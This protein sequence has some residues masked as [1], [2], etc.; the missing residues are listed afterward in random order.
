MALV[1][2]PQGLVRRGN[3]WHYRRRIPLD[4]VKHFGG[5]REL[6]ESLATSDPAKAKTLRN[7]VAA[8]FDVQFAAARAALQTTPVSIPEISGAEALIRIREYVAQ[9][10]ALR[11]EQFASTSWADHPGMRHN[12]LNQATALAESYK[13]PSD[14]LTFR[15]IVRAGGAIFQTANIEML[16][17]NWAHLHRAVLEL[18]RRELARIKADFRDPTSDHLFGGEISHARVPSRPLGGISLDELINKYR[19]EYAKTKVVGEKRVGKLTAAM[20]LISRF[21]GNDTPV[22]MIDRDRCR[23]FRDLLNQLPA[24][25]QKLF[26]DRR[27][28]FDHIVLETKNQKRKLL[29][30]PTQDVYF[31]FLKRLLRFAKS[32]GYI[33]KYP[34]DDLVPLAKKSSAREA[35]DPFS[36]EQLNSIFK[37]PL[38]RGCENDQSGYAVEGPNVIRGT[39]FWIPLVAL[40]TGMR[41]NEICQ[42]DVADI[43]Q[44]DGGTW[45][46]AVNDDGPDKSL[47]TDH[48]KR[49]IPLHPDL[50][51]MGFVDFVQE[52]RAKSAKLFSDLKRTSRGYHSER[53]SR[54]F[55]EGL[56]PKVNA[57]TDKTSFHSFRHCFRD[58]LRNIDAPPAVVQGL[59]GWETEGGV[60]GGYG[61]GLS[62]DKLMLWTKNIQYDGLDLSHLY[63]K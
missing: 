18:K 27:V 48:S 22:N 61:K 37:A 58:A 57:K 62:V 28:T 33:D 12:A 32:E 50:M 7:V 13:D 3:V 24:N 35:R 63:L 30:R 54:W 49:V 31:N 60:S 38:Y 16:E 29:A 52:H 20:D 44:S 5:K 41:L 43:C 14:D 21:F 6:K 51:R 53:M 23:D 25:L 11:A 15:A 40:F 26:S 46:I 56:L 42:L 17:E 36:T 45:F 9:E 4:L 47:K 2:K 39:R 59:G 19:A 1:S 8:K 10:D 34:A 55:N